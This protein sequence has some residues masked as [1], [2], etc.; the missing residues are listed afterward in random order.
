MHAA[1]NADTFRTITNDGA[2]AISCWA[3]VDLLKQICLFTMC[4]GST[5]T[6]AKLILVLAPKIASVLHAA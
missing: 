3:E 2:A 6:T 4:N 1:C 5:S